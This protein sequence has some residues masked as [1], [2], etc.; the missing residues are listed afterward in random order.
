MKYYNFENLPLTQSILAE[1]MVDYSRPND[2]IS[3]LIEKRELVH[4]ARGFYTIKN[5]SQQNLY[6]NYNA[7]NTMYGVSYISKYSAL[8]YFN[9]LSE[10]VFTVESM[11]L[12]RPREINN[13]LGRFTYSHTSEA[14]FHIG[15]KSI[16]V[17]SFCTFLMASPEKALCDIIW[18]TKSLPISSLKDMVYFLE[19]D[20]RF[21]MDF[22]TN[23]NVQIFEECIESGN[24]KKELKYLV[25]LCKEYTL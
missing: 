21:E 17:N 19:E 23:A 7:A 20:I 8:S 15:I 6:L 22:F 14:V 9:L 13:E 3:F 18:S 5:H 16:N 1:S 12:K 11:T 25:K 2:R 24:K 10:G 4:L